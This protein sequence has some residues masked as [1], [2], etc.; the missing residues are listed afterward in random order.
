MLAIPA[1]AG[2]GKAAVWGLILRSKGPSMA[3]SCG[4]SSARHGNPEIGPFG[5]GG[6]AFEEAPVVVDAY[7]PVGADL[8]FRGSAGRRR[9]ETRQQ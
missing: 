6:F 7:P 9:S 5:A 8:D 1:G 3:Q 2:D 4:R